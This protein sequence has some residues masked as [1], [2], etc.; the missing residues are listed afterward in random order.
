[1][2]NKQQPSALERITV[3]LA[4]RSRQAL[5]EAMARSGDSKTDTVNRALQ[6]YNYLE[7]LWRNDGVVYI[8][9]AA[10]GEL[11]RLRVF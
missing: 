4:P 5:A 11:E 2:Q 9:Q 10:G 8:R 3:N 1:M 7:D 6:V